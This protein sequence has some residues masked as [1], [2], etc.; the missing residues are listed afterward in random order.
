MVGMKITANFKGK[1]ALVADD[2]I[3]NLELTKDMMELMGCN[4]DVAENGFVAL[5]KYKN[6]QYDVIMMDVQMP[7]LDGYEVT[8]KIREF[9]DSGDK[10]HTIIMALTANAL[11]GD[12]EKCLSAGMD[13]YIS[14]PLSPK[15]VWV[16][17]CVLRKF[18]HMVQ[19]M[20]AERKYEKTSIS[21]RRN[22]RNRG[23][24]F[25]S[26]SEGWI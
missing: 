10:K 16:L 20:S 5:E 17:Q 2:H 12:E 26:S 4:V 11:Q 9:E 18:R 25:Q 15:K 24:Y 23:A 6:K 3:V 8:K 14:K 22:Q 1:K 7:E 19:K 13:D 21:Y